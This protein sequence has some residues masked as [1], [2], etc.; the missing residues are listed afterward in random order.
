[1]VSLEGLAESLSDGQIP[2]KT[3]ANTLPCVGNRCIIPRFSIRQELRSDRE[4]DCEQKAK[5]GPSHQK[6]GGTGKVRQAEKA[7]R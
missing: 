3:G 5:Q 6:E 2:S 4:K 1:M 7:S